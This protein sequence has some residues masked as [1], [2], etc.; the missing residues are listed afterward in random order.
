MQLMLE[1]RAI[2]HKELTDRFKIKLPPKVRG[3]LNDDDL[4]STSKEAGRLVHEITDKGVEWC[5]KD[6]VRGDAPTHA[7][8]LAR[9]HTEMLRR[10]I[11]FLHRRGLLVEAVRSEDLESLI[12]AVYGDLASAPEE[13]I[14]LARI[15]PRLNGAEKSQVDEVLLEMLKTGTVHLAPD[16]NTKML[17]ADDRAAAVRIGGEDLHLIAIEESS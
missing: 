4:M 15:R 10:V 16:S 9:A 13:W 5:M 2:P 7:G 6:L 14:R 11:G 17:S 1:D 12:R 8:P 3:P